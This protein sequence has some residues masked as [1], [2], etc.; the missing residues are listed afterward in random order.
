MAT[1]RSRTSEV[2]EVEVV[3]RELGTLL[4]LDTATLDQNYVYRWIHKSPLKVSRARA[5]GYTMVDPGT[6]EV[7]I[8]VTGGAPETA[9][10]TY[11][12]GDVVLMKLLKSEHRARRIASK[13][14]TDK[15]LKGPV[16]KFK[17]A[18]Q[19]KVQGRYNQS[20]EI[21]SKKDPHPQED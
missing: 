21:I 12:I 14:K 19:E 7:L 16:R 4:E 17:R 11:T 20:V 15:R 10:G 9:D 1:S 8:V 2:P 5:R 3:S 6:E 18:A 13:R